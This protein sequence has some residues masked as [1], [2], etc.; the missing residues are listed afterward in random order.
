MIKQM[1]ICILCILLITG[2]S[3]GS[4]YDQ[5]ETK[6]VTNE[7]YDSLTGTLEE[8][9]AVEKYLASKAETSSLENVVVLMGSKLKVKSENQKLD[10]IN[11]LMRPMV[12]NVKLDLDLFSPVGPIL[13][14]G[15]DVEGNFVVTFEKDVAYDSSVFDRIYTAFKAEGLKRGMT[16]VPVLFK[17]SEPMQ[18]VY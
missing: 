15:V 2:V 10:I 11:N 8:S 6:Y 16:D 9:E 18:L 12:E 7:N 14:Y 1:G 4:V 5:E 17:L 13:S 3:T